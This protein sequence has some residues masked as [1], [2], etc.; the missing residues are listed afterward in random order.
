MFLVSHRPHQSLLS[1]TWLFTIFMLPALHWG[2][3]VCNTWYV[4]PTSSVLW[5]SR[6]GTEI[7]CTKCMLNSW[8]NGS[9]DTDISV[10]S[11][12]S[13][14]FHEWN[15]LKTLSMCVTLWRRV[16]GKELSCSVGRGSVK[17]LMTLQIIGLE[18]VEYME[19]HFFFPVFWLEVLRPLLPILV[20]ILFSMCSI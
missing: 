8:V 3:R 4:S 10:L 11:W 15:F 7:A 6:P 5:L 19:N 17:F 12:F 14:T 13:Y 16:N 18:F 9:R 1:Y 20:I 2:P